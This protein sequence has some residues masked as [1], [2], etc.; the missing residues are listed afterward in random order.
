ML[1]NS[2]LSIFLISVTVTIVKVPQ[3]KLLFHKFST[4]LATFNPA[5][6]FS[7]LSLILTFLLLQSENKMSA[8]TAAKAPGDTS[9]ETGESVRAVKPD[10][11]PLNLF[12]ADG[13]KGQA[14]SSPVLPERCTEAVSPPKT[15]VSA[16]LAESTQSA[17][18]S[19][20]GK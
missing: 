2:S 5:F 17:S 12:S 8:T 15:P 6:S 11:D 19:E 4:N 3:K 14:S 13:D 9:P 7:Y 16:S 10:T 1:A 18:H 20:S